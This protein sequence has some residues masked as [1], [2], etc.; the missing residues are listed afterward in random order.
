MRKIVALCIALALLMLAGCIA[1]KTD[2]MEELL[3][4]D[5]KVAAVQGLLLPTVPPEAEKTPEPTPEPTPV[6]TDT[7]VPEYLPTDS[8]EKDGIYELI[9]Y[10]GTQSVVAYHAEN[11]EWV[12]CRTMICSTGKR[13][14]T[15]TYS[16]HAKKRYHS[17]F[18]A[19]GQYC[20]RIVDSILFHSV[21]IDENAKDLETGQRRMKLEEYEKLGTPASDGC[22]RLPCV[23]AQWVYETCDE[24]TRVIITEEEGPVPTKPPELIYGEPYETETG[25]GWDPTDTCPDNPY[26]QT[27][28]KGPQ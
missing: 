16:L 23:D 26:L 8:P 22:V 14:P 11:G 28:E 17:L 2:D 7:P 6:P 5:V 1:K 21:P 27:E 4:S 24:K 18:G 25:Y 12:P 19:K 15:G 9:V 3:P 13:T 20:S 10:V